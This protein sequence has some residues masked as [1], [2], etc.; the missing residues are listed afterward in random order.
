VLLMVVCQIFVLELRTSGRAGATRKYLPHTSGLR[1][2]TPHHAQVPASSRLPSRCTTEAVFD[3]TLTT[4]YSP[5]SRY[6]RRGHAAASTSHS[7][8]RR[9]NAAAFSPHT[10]LQLTNPQPSAISFLAPSLCHASL[11]PSPSCLSS[12][13]TETT[14]KHRRHRVTLS[15]ASAGNHIRTPTFHTRAAGPHCTSLRPITCIAAAHCMWLSA[16]SESLIS[17][18][19]SLVSTKHSKRTPVHRNHG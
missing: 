12:R 7:V 13:G 15:Q 8:S 3:L 19:S 14:R 1:F 10:V 11:A 18:I 5:R 6:D 4:A 9:A 16:C 17:N 2:P